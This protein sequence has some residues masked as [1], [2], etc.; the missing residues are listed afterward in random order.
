MKEIQDLVNKKSLN[1]VAIIVTYN[2]DDIL[3]RSLEVLCAQFDLVVIID[4]CSTNKSFIA[5]LTSLYG[6]KLLINFL[7]ENYGIA[8]A[9]NIGIEI[10]ERYGNP[11]VLTLDQDS[12]V[13]KDF[14][15]NYKSVIERF[16]AS[17]LAPGYYFTGAKL[18]ASI[19]PVTYAITSGQ[20]TKLDL[21]QKV[22][23]FD[24]EFFI[25]GVDFDFSLKIINVGETIFKVNSA[26]IEHRLGDKSCGVP[27]LRRFHT[28]HNPVRRYYIYRNMIFL[29]KKYFL[30]NTY[31]VIKHVTAN[32]IYIF[33][34]ILLG[35]RR[36]E[37]LRYIVRGVFHG[38]IGRSGRFVE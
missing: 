13:C 12:I 18:D 5:S 7:N 28:Y 31:F 24:D 29:I 14:L 27:I 10:C 16:N 33:T 20:M 8:A 11:W 4:N 9:L 26:Y 35:E 23:G 17:S 3:I 19:S 25:D 15:F 37:S 6:D 34:I 36:L 1:F 21:I 30:K 2:P 22:G 38:L 32:F